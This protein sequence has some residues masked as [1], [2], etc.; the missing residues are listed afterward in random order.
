MTKYVLGFL[1]DN[2]RQL[3]ALIEKQKPEWQKGYLNGIGGKVESFD[4]DSTDA[5][6]REFREE[7]GVETFANGWRMFATMKGKDW[8]VDCFVQ[9]SSA[10]MSKVISATEERIH[11]IH[12]SA[13]E[14]HKTLSNVPWLVPMALDQNMG[15]PPF[16]ADIQ[17]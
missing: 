5:M 4:I 9:F 17:Y 1:F 11:I 13:I 14:H 2:E 10:A 8:I 16:F 12:V 15:N 6:V 3:V 7:A